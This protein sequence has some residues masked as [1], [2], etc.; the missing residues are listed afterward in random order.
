MYSLVGQAVD[1]AYITVGTYSAK[2]HMGIPMGHSSSVILLNIYLFMYEYEWVQKVLVMQ[3]EMA[4]HTKD[5]FRY[6]DDLGNFSDIDI[7][8]YL[9][10][11]ETEPDSMNW[12][13]PLHP[14]GPLAIT[15]QNEPMD[16]GTRFV[17]LNLDCVYQYGRLSYSWYDKSLKY[18][19]IGTA[20]YTHWKSCI[21]RGCKLGTVSSQVR[22][23]LLSASSL[24]S[25]RAGIVRL[26]T[27]LAGID[28]PP[29]VITTKI[30]SAI[31]QH[32]PR[33]PVPYS[34]NGAP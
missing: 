8:M 34:L 2:Q 21:S 16:G 1:L 32:Y 6:V 17:Y 33:L 22:A 12:I 31:L 20:V 25:L 4:R 11:T 26:A 13:Y 10:P 30:Q 23:V 29:D 5:I 27:K 15:C 24:Q 7:A 18:K 9:I 3:P 19:D 14:F 28:Y